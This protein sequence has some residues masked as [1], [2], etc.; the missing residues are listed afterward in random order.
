MLQQYMVNNFLGTLENIEHG[1]LVLVTPDSK[2][3][4]FF[5]SHEPKAVICKKLERYK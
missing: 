2:T 1:T 4:T 5:G 3:Y